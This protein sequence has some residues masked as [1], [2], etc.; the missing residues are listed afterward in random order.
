MLANLAPLLDEFL[1]TVAL[2]FGLSNAVHL[3]LLF[4]F[5]VIHRLLVFIMQVDVR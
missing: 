3:V 2:L 5:Y 4:P 1:N